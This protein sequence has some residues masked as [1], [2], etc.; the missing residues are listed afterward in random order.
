MIVT[1]PHSLDLIHRM[2][3]TDLRKR[4]SNTYRLAKTTVQYLLKIMEDHPAVPLSP[5]VLAALHSYHGILGISM[6]LHFLPRDL[7]VLVPLYNAKEPVYARLP[8]SD[9]SIILHNAG[10]F[11]HHVLTPS[12]FA[13]H[14]TR[15][16]VQAR[17]LRPP[18]EAFVSARLFM[19]VRFHA[20]R[21]VDGDAGLA[22]V[23][24]EMAV[25]KELQE[26]AGP[27]R[28]ALVDAWGEWWMPGKR[29]TAEQAAK[30]CAAYFRERHERQEQESREKNAAKGGGTQ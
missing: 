29:M 7:A 25:L 26:A 28:A 8:P 14:I 16:Q 24:R 30:S 12:F 1:S 6:H 27:A 17:A 23:R 5:T 18:V 3:F 20:P 9:I 19:G 10:D 21:D 22:A 4:L 2:P 13:Q 15:L 11:L